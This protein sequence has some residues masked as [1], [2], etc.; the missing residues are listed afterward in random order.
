MA[1]PRYPPLEDTGGKES[2]SNK[3]LVNQSPL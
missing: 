3:Q 1:S 2:N